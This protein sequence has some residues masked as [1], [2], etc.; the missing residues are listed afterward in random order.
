[1]ETEAVREPLAVGVKTTLIVHVPF[2]A[3][4]AGLTGQLLVWPKSPAL[5]PVMPMVA[6]V[7]APGPLFVT[8]T[9]CA[10]LVVL[11]I[12]LANV[13]VDGDRPTA[14][15]GPLLVSPV[16]AEKKAAGLFWLL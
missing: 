3:S 7:S 6:I 2:T 15:D 1:M 5:V 11:I 16:T 14:G 10:A 12:W 13:R 8:V 9:A 4:V